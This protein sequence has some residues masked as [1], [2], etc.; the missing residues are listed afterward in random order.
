MQWGKDS[1]GSFTDL[2]EELT[3]G[4]CVFLQQFNPGSI[5]LLFVQA[6]VLGE[7]LWL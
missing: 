1:L 4:Q 3:A 6:L 7:L 5:R 2:P